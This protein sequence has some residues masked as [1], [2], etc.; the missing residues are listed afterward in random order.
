MSL[1]GNYL[2]T[3]GCYIVKPLNKP[4]MVTHSYLYTPPC[5]LLL[6]S[7]PVKNLFSAC[8]KHDMGFTTCA[9]EVE[10]GGIFFYIQRHD[11]KGLK[12]VS[13]KVFKGSFD[14]LKACVKEYFSPR[15][16]STETKDIK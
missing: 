11:V 9:E 4:N 10:V 6:L 5:P 16:V 12:R 2:H 7:C 8:L 15:G 13:P 14:T 3:A 1:R